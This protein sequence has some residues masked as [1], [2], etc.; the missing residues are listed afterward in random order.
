MVLVMC[1]NMS[2]KW[3]P[4]FV[5][6]N[7]VSIAPSSSPGKTCCH[8]L[9]CLCE[10]VHTCN[11]PFTHKLSRSLTRLCAR[12]VTSLTLHSFNR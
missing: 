8:R 3:W 5:D 4:L 6:A 2:I 11:L 9:Y 12:S 1:C 10:W 7:V